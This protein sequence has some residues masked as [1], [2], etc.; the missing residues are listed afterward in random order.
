MQAPGLKS[1][2]MV[3]VCFH[4][5]RVDGKGKFESFIILATWGEQWEYFNNYFRYFVVVNECLY[6]KSLEGYR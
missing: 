3:I 6:F 1:Y 4:E 5:M 2:F